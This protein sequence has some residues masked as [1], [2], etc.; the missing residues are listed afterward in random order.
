MLGRGV[1]GRDRAL[2]HSLVVPTTLGEMTYCFVRGEAV[3][4]K[5]DIASSVTV[6]LSGGSTKSTADIPAFASL[7]TC[8]FL[9]THSLPYD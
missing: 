7:L 3:A 5:N 6:R 2:M 4:I 1:L 9:L 8:I